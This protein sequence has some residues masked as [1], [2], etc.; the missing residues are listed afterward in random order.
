[1]G[2]RGRRSRAPIGS[3]GG[4]RSGGAVR[5]GKQLP[6][7]KRDAFRPVFLRLNRQIQYKRAI[8][9]DVAVA[10]HIAQAFKAFLDRAGDEIS[11]ES[12]AAVS[13]VDQGVADHHPAGMAIRRDR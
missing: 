2:R 6:G 8:K 9:R 1:M 11:N 4:V 10:D 5:A 7:A 3:S 13:Q 12:D